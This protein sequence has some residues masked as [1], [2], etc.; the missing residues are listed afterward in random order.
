M[1][2]AVIIPMSYSPRPFCLFPHFPSFVTSNRSNPI[3]TDSKKKKIN[4]KSMDTE[5]SSMFLVLLYK[6]KY[7]IYKFN[8]II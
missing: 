7:N 1:S 4:K 5:K 6:H 8:K 2:K 3:Q